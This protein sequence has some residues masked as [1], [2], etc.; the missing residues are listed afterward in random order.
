MS[1]GI[2]TQGKPAV[3]QLWQKGGSGINNN[4]NHKNTHTITTTKQQRHC[5][6]ATDTATTTSKGGPIAYRS[7]IRPGRG[8]RK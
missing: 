4:T 2:G 8:H 6:T 1:A 5:H 7:R 3:W